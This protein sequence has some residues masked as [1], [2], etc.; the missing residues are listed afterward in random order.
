MKGAR[1]LLVIAFT[2]TALVGAAIGIYTALHSPLFLVQVVEVADIPESAPVDSSSIAQLAAIPPGIVNLFD[3]D[4][5]AVESRILSNP[6][7]REVRLQKRFPQTL[8]IS[9]GFRQPRALVQAPNGSLSYVDADG[10][11]F[12]QVNLRLAS[13]LPVISGLMREPPRK[14]AEALQVLDVWERS[15]ASK[16]A[17]ISSLNWDSERGFRAL[18]SY[19]MKPSSPPAKAKTGKTAKNAPR[20]EVRPA[21][22]RGRAMVDL[23]QEV[24][25][26]LDAQFARLSEVLKYLSGNSI[27]VHQIWADAGKK[28]VVKSAHGS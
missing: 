22:L 6:W 28:I 17:Q 24:D 21:T 1:K 4:L 18:I 15:E 7:I 11:I 12:G 10:R 27:S 5:R 13:D 3:L 14:M 2:T 20:T 23:G 19:A 26:R 9:V 8:S 16:Q 25:D